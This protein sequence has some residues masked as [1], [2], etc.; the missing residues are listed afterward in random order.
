MDE[1]ITKKMICS[2]RI[3]L[4]EKITPVRFNTGSELRYINALVENTYIEIF[5]GRKN[6]TIED[7]SAKRMLR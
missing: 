2:E 3:I 4:G 1:N 5:F 7:C 6:A